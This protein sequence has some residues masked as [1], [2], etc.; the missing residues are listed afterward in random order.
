MHIRGMDVSHDAVT[1]RAAQ[2][3]PPL[4]EPES[5][6][7]QLACGRLQPAR[8]G[9][10]LSVEVFL[11]SLVKFYEQLFDLADHGCTGTTRIFHCFAQGVAS[12]FD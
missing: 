8:T 7:A 12:V 5:H 3:V 9:S 4:H 11:Y 10:P 2:G 6:R 1:Y